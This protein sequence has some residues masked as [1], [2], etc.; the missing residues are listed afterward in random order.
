MNNKYKP[1]T[2]FP[3]GGI[4]SVEK[5][6][7]D[8][9]MGSAA[10]SN[11][12]LL[13]SNASGSM[14]GYDLYLIDKIGD[15]LPVNSI[16]NIGDKNLIAIGTSLYVG[17]SN[18]SSVIESNAVSTGS[19]FK[20]LDLPENETITDIIERSEDGL[21]LLSTSLGRIISCQ[22]TTINAYFTGD[23]T[24][25]ADVT[26]GFGLSNASYT[27]LMY[28]LYNKIAE[29]NKDREI[30][31]WK[32]TTKPSAILVEKITGE[33]LSPILFVREDLGFWKELIWE[34]IKPT[35]TDIVIS[36]RSGDSEIE[37]MNKEWRNAF[38]SNVGETGIIT[39]ELNNTV[40]TGQYLQV[41]VEMTTNKAN[42]TPIVSNVTIKYSTKQA[43]YFFTTKFTLAKD[44]MTDRGIFVA[45]M[46]QPQ[47]TEVK[48]GIA[49]KETS[50]WD[51]FT[52]YAPDKF[53]STDNMND[54]KIGIKFV[55]YDEHV[56]EVAEF[57]LLLGGEKVKVISG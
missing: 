34:E 18:V 39:R 38:S 53:F 17:S 35:D 11:I 33:F 7:N 50:N 30:E 43:S 12:Y 45:T 10:D 2:S 37:V 56:P 23:R 49:G 5:V 29:V 47:N 48:F 13:S 42:A 21:I 9:F 55:S 20:I 36:I 27:S 3:D 44:S 57:A 24:I 46:T 41:K 1:L 6:G 14:M 22:D 4:K 26:D 25:Y 16:L 8:L 32:F 19:S 31:K 51:D 28:A 52:S 54:V 40:L 15:G